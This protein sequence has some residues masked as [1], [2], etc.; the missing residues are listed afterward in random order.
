[1]LTPEEL[2]RFP[3]R[4]VALYQG[5][6]DRVL[7]DMAERLADAGEMIPTAQWQL[8]KMEQLGNEEEYIRQQLRR[9]TGKSDEILTEIF[10]QAG[11]QALAFDD[12]IYQKAGLSP[13]PILESDSIKSL[14]YSGMK[15]TKSVFEN[16]TGTIANT[17][18]R[19]FESVLD[20]VWMDVMIGAF[21]YQ[22][23]IVRGVKSLSQKGI[24]AIQYPSG[25]TDVI[26]VAVRRA[27]LT[28]VNQ[29]TAELS[30][31][32]ADEMECDLVETTAHFGA[33]LSHT[34]W[35]GRVFSRSGRSQKYPDFVRET[36]YGTGPGLCGWNCHH[37]LYP[38]FEGISIR[39]Y[40]QKE[41]AQMNRKDI[42][43]QG[44]KMTRYEASQKQRYI[45]QNIRKYKREYL[46]LKAAKLDT[47]HTSVNL[48]KWNRTL[49][50]FVN[51]TGLQKD[52]SRT[53]V[54]GFGRSQA[55]KA[56][57]QSRRALQT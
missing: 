25:K 6:E 30:L 54:L 20:E 15:K 52:Y 26:D 23:A 49:D 40:T 41:L 47:S 19:Q 53:Q 3:D 37:S 10:E 11:T 27:V 39:A 18:T 24:E 33:R 2:D 1:M 56:A 34:Y 12:A 50:D 7:Q 29:A 32:R 55:S 16:L 22:N 5:L 48:S 31:A 17:A 51:Q 36:G 35:Q 42:T 13:N 57:D 14:L 45:E 21:S 38:Y 8:W 28:G 44:E 43:Y 9:L 46:G 4:T